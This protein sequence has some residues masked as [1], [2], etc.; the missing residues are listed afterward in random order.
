MRST[1]LRELPTISGT[2]GSLRY[3]KWQAEGGMGRIGRFGVVCEEI[4]MYHAHE[5]EDA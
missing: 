1:H 4:Q 2:N 3:L 5:T